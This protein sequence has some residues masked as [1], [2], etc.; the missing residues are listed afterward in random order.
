[1][2]KNRNNKVISWL[3]A[4]GMTFIL[5]SCN[6]ESDLAVNREF[7]VHTLP[8]SEVVNEEIPVFYTTTGSVISDDRIQITSR[9]TSYIG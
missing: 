6:Q 3:F 9:I 5:S 4:V 2:V 7:T 1:M 8:V